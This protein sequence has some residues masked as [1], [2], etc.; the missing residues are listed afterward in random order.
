M[1]PL[2]GASLHEETAARVRACAS[3]RAWTCVRV[4]EKSMCCMHVSGHVCARVCESTPACRELQEHAASHST[5]VKVNSLCFGFRA[6]IKYLYRSNFCS[7]LSKRNATVG[8]TE[9]LKAT[10]LFS[11]L[12]YPKVDLG[13]GGVHSN[14]EVLLFFSL[15][16]FAFLH[17]SCV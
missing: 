5:A 16:S 7:H 1:S 14:G 17:L 10:Y 8:C 12:F 4:N 6:E 15:P 2:P 3:E 11:I 9:L 13:G